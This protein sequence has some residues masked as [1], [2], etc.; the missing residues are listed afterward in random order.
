MDA[1]VPLADNGT[2]NTCSLCYVTWD[3]R[4]I[5]DPLL[6]AVIDIDGT[7]PR[8]GIMHLLGRSRPTP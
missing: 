3:V 8:A 6:P 5:K 1:S 4:R 7:S 2:I